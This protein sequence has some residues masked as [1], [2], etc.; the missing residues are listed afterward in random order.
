MGSYTLGLD[1]SVGFEAGILGPCTK[2]L[3]QRDIATVKHTKAT[4]V[5]SDGR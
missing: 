4:G 1:L 3:V 5:E 2:V